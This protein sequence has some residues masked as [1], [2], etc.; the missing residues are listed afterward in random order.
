MWDGL[1]SI[2]DVLVIIKVQFVAKLL[3]NIIMHYCQRLRTYQDILEWQKNHCD[4]TMVLQ[5]GSCLSLALR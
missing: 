1:I 3:D 2:W 4:V 5:S